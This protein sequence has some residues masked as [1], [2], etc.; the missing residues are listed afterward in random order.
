MNEAFETLNEKFE[1]PP[2]LVLSDFDSAFRVEIDPSSMAVGV[3][4]VQK[5]DNVRIS[6]LQ[7]A[8]LTQNWAERNY[9][10]YESVCL[11]V[12]FA[13]RKFLVYFLLTKAFRLV[14]H[15]RHL[16]YAFK[17]N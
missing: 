11:A 16:R 15:H 9:S 3:F 2:A 4:L 1:T 14:I 7:Y 6:T 5:K 8:S 13:F 12:R 10:A 17:M